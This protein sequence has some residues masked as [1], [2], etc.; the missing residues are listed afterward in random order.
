MT[1]RQLRLMDIARKVSKTSGYKFK[2]GTVI[3][4]GNR[5]LGLG[6]NSAN[7]THPKSTS[8]FKTLH[9]EHAALINSGLAEIQGSIA[10]V[11]RETKSG[12]PAMSK[13][14]PSCE[15]LLRK[16]G[17]KKVYY[18]IDVFPFWRVEEYV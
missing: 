6:V 7:K 12:E 15:K 11:Y 10:F 1:N 8:R 17:V 9:S 16:A 13:P 4:K 2:H 14:C 5:V 18:S 3:A